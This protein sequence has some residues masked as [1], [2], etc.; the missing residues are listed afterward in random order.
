MQLHADFLYSSMPPVGTKVRTPSFP[1]PRAIVGAGSA[2]AFFC[3]RLRAG[4]GVA[5][6][7]GSAADGAD[8]ALGFAADGEDAATGGAEAA[9][10][11]AGL[12][13]AEG[14]NAGD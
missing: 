1:G 10:A 12:D 6:D 8:A 13:A 14:E 5:D 11:T 9:L 7:A 3:P 4:V 2:G